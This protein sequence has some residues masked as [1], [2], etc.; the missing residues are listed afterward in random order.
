[1]CVM[2]AFFKEM[3]QGFLRKKKLE[4]MLPRKWLL[5]NHKVSSNFFWQFYDNCFQKREGNKETQGGF[6]RTHGL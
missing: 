1:M 4:H 2:N 3:L 6:I 5:E